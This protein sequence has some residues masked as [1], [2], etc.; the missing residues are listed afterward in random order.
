MSRV[1]LALIGVVLAFFA[2][3]QVTG[4]GQP[5]SPRPELIP[6][7]PPPKAVARPTPPA[8]AAAPVTRSVAAASSTPGPTS[9]SRTPTIDRLIR[10]ETRRRLAQSI[11]MTYLDSLVT[12]TDSTIR[13]WGDRDGRPIS[14]V[15]DL[16]KEPNAARFVPRVQAAMQQWEALGLGLH[17]VVTTDTTAADVTVHW[18]DRFE[19]DR[20]GQADLQG[21]GDGAFTTGRVTIAL[22]DKA[23]RVLTD[24]EIETIATHEFGHV[25][26]LPHS[27]DRADIMFPV[28]TV[29]TLSARDRATAV[30]LYSLPPGT[31]R[32]PPGQ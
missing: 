23:K 14:V 10:L 32:E 29:T 8:A 28:A 11:R 24:R 12:G 3:A 6:P 7:P 5:A 30:L 4:A 22:H 26:G 9:E 15:I 31:L 25:I 2:I 13:R 19:Q 1:F 20:T 18:I 27:G 21:G 17:F 16:P